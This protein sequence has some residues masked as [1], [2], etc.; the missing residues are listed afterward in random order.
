VNLSVVIPTY[1][2]PD[3]LARTLEA[4]V[5]QVHDVP[6]GCE[7][8]VVDD[9][10]GDRTPDVMASFAERLPLVA[11]G[12]P[13]NEGRA[14][15]RNRGWRA[16]RGGSVLFLDDDIVLA[17]GSLAAHASAQ[18]R[19][20]AGYLGDVVTAPEVVD[21]TLFAYL[22]TRGVAKLPPGAR[23]PARYLL[24]QNVSVPRAALKAVGGFDEEFGAYG[25]ED[26]EIGFRLEEQAG[27]DFFRLEAARGEHIHH[28]SLRE[29]LDKKV[30]CGQETLPQLARLH[31]GRVEEM[32]LHVLPLLRWP[33]SGTDALGRAGL[34]G[35]V[36][37]R[38]DAILTRLVAV[39]PGRLWPSGLH[40]LYD[41][42]VLAAYE[43]GLRSR[44]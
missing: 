30:L 26:M 15:A 35:I 39:W 3:L 6:E 1:R 14:R 43:R 11:A 32:R 44:S 13:H 41:L 19:R 9:G 28:H 20:P 42:L 23:A 22:D 37:S 27:V 5:P 7:V 12:P 2:K 38:L 4:L 33:A 10:S 16:A 24:T 34:G 36:A 21:S 18:A 31:P 29:Y 40:R 25:F 17:P 8:V